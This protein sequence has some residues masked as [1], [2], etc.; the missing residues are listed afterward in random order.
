[1][2]SE[3]FSNPNKMFSGEVNDETFR[4]KIIGVG[5]AGNNAVDRIKLDH[6]DEVDLA[7]VNTDSKVLSTS[8]L[9]EKVM[10]GREI[11]RGLSAGGDADIGKRAAES[12][13]DQLLQLVNGIDLVFII[14]GLGGGTGSGAAPVLAE[15]AANQ[16]ALVI[17]FVTLPFTNEG[18][19]R[20]NQAEESLAQLRDLCHAVIPLPNDIL[21]QQVDDSATV[22]DAFT[23]AD[24]W[25]YRGVH[26][27][28][29]M[30]K[31]TGLINVD[32]ATLRNAFENRGGKTLFG[33]GYGE[34]DN[35]VDKT[36][37]DLKLCPLLHTP[38]F[39]KR[40]DS[41]IVNIYGGTDLTI[42]KVNE[43]MT[44]VG[45]Q[46]GSKD[47][48]VLGAYI[49]ESMQQKLSITVLGTTNLDGVRR[50]YPSVKPAFEP[51]KQ[52]QNPK[53]KTGK[54]ELYS[55][56]VHESKINDQ[57]DRKIN[58][59]EFMFSGEDEQ[60]GY[61]NKTDRNFYEGEDLDV[62]TYLRRG[63]KINL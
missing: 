32:F 31:K 53:S 7:V 4:I 5:G 28:W 18:I 3:N 54:E 20:H 10:I 15:I 34:G 41:L 59:K 27:I 38:E 2:Q 8:L 57:N 24:E 63:I 26:S 49:D 14:A 56:A 19:R 6:L 58:Q 47:N 50:R 61:F 52:V 11:T 17:A 25:I 21:L 29:S 13:R 36:F 44:V 16:E 37:D 43:I 35:Y 39:S 12:D 60:R 42:K 55:P 30:I 51:I 40:A 62:P 45:D 1:M 23:L 9:E 48:I 33:L 46:F 22:L